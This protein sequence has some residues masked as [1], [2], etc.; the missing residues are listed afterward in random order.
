M[1]LKAIEISLAMVR[2]RN[3]HYD[4][5]DVADAI[6]HDISVIPAYETGGL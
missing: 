1:G 2:Q 3:G 4:L 6:D 5:S